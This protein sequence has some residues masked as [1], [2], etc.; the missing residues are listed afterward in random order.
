MCL[1]LNVEDPPP[2][3]VPPEHVRQTLLAL[4]E[5]PSRGRAIVLELEGQVC[6]YA[7]LIA[8]WSNELGGEVC[9]ID[10]LYVEPEYRGRRHATRLIDSL[11]TGEGLWSPKPVALTL[12]VT[13]NNVRARQLYE[14]AGFRVHNLAMRRRLLP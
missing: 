11:A 10:E 5:V 14:R 6:G 3:P 8:Y 13:P 2:H 7:L 1:A 9:T 12:E 4:R